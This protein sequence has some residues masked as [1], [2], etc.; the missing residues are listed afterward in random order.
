MAPVSK[1]AS[2]AEAFRRRAHRHVDDERGSGK[3]LRAG[4]GIRIGLGKL[5]RPCDL[6]CAGDA[7]CDDALVGNP[8]H[9]AGADAAASTTFI[10]TISGGGQGELGVSATARRD[11]PGQYV[12]T[13]LHVITG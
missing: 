10:C 13:Y 1:V 8:R 2:V 11:A 5:Q 7:G 9:R 6:G 4:G 12:L 3:A